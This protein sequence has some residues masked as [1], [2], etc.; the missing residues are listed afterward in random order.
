MRG[1]A[2]MNFT[3]RSGQLVVITQIP[4]K[5][6]VAA[7]VLSLPFLAFSLFH[8]WT[9]TDADGKWFSL[10]FG[11]FTGWLMLEYPATRE[12]FEIDL[13]S[14]TL[15]RSVIGVFRKSIRRVNLGQMKQINLEIRK[16]WRGTRYQYLFIRGD[17]EQ[18]LLNSPNKRLNHVATG[19]LLSSVTGIPYRPIEGVRRIDD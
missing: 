16:N 12:K 8:I 14:K 4:L 5:L 2:G 11:T 3:R 18:F 13:S 7:G 10:F 9:G 6:L 17:H 19:M 15:R 1:D